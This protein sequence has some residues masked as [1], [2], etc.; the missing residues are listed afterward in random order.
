MSSTGV[1]EPN[2]T[3][4]RVIKG[5]IQNES[6]FIQSLRVFANTSTLSGLGSTEG[7]INNSP[8]EASGNYLS[9]LGDKM[10]GPLALNPP[11]DF[12]IDID[13][14]N[15]I[16]IGPLNDN[17][18]YTSNVQLDD[19][20]TNGF[21]LDIIAGAAFDGQLLVLRTFAPSDPFTISQGT[22]ANGGNI[23]T[24][25]GNDLTVGDLQAVTLIF[26]EALK[27]EANL[28][29]SWRVLSVSSGGGSGGVDLLPLDNIW[30]GTNT[31]TGTV[32][33][34]TS[35]SITLGDTPADIISFGGVMGTDIDL[36]TFDLKNVDR[37]LFASDSGSVAVTDVGF[38][39]N[40]KDLISNTVI[41]GSFDWLAGGNVVM[42]LFHDTAT[43]DTIFA[44]TAIDAD[45]IPIIETISVDTTPN[46]ETP[47]GRLDFVGFNTV[48]AKTSYAGLLAEHEHIGNGIEEGSLFLKAMTAGSLTTYLSLNDALNGEIVASRNIVAGGATLGMSNIGQLIF[49]DDNALNPASAVALYSEL[50]DLIANTGGTV[51]NLSNIGGIF[52]DSVFKIQSAGDPTKQLIFNIT[53]ITPLNTRI[54]TWPDANGEVVTSPA[55]LDIDLNTFDISN[56]DSVQFMGSISGS[57]S[58][59]ARGITPVDATGLRIQVVNDGKFQV[60]ED[61]A[62]VI[63]F[64]IDTATNVASFNDTTL[65]ILETAGTDFLDIGVSETLVTF[66]SSINHMLFSIGITNIIRLENTG[67]TMQSLA[68]TGV[69]TLGMAAA[70]QGIESLDAGTMRLVSPTAISFHSNDFNVEFGK[71]DADLIATT[72]FPFLALE[73]GSIILSSISNPPDTGA[74]SIGRIFMDDD[75]SNHLSIKRLTTVIDLETGLIGGLDGIQDAKQSS[76]H[77]T[78]QHNFEFWM[79][80]AKQGD[81]DFDHLDHEYFSPP[82][83]QIL[84]LPIYIGK[85][86]RIGRAGIDVLDPVVGAND[87]STAIYDSYPDQNYPRNRIT[88]SENQLTVSSGIQSA[89]FNEDVESGLY[90]IAIWF[91]NGVTN[92]I[93]NWPGSSANVVNWSPFNGDAGPMEAIMGYFEVGH[94]SPTLP[95]VAP[96]NMGI[97][98]LNRTPAVF[99][100][101]TPNLS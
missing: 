100:K 8:T 23:Q 1:R 98:T 88:D 21:V 22:G 79:S 12:T 80:N 76:V 40:N 71:F 89:F 38:V 32:F 93:R 51:V 87:W 77:E 15:T 9:R 28:G 81:L 101:L 47:V 67:L 34:V 82:Q 26:D 75:N 24:G 52:L 49:V 86:H 69:S 99:A 31:F 18:Q 73:G 74:I 48:A 58:D 27:I 68:V 43:N 92:P 17:A 90:W 61:A 14:N 66:N 72:P 44:V 16:D 5:L 84:Y 46:A 56:V 19:E 39:R 53:D 65:R 95:T 78:T 36:G 33:S 57:L 96:D 70:G 60:T 94:T 63:P 37:L 55:Q 13:A 42:A 29:G 83:E 3:N 64:E 10:L 50:G 35:P 85:R 4:K 97:L 2:D 30:L 6:Q 7:E 54:F 91:D 41:D 20:Q 25:D 45:G 62:A 59:G 11:L